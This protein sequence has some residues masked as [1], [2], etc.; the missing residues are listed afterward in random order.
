MQHIL[1]RVPDLRIND[2]RM[3]PFIHLLFVTDP[4]GID[5][6][7]QDVLEVTTIKVLSA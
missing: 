6:V 7:A 3:L 1:N 4:S 5:R 2:R